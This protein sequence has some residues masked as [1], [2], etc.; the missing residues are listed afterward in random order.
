MLIG[1][2]WTFF[3]SGLQFLIAQLKMSGAM[4]GDMRLLVL[5]MIEPSAKTSAAGRQGRKYP[6]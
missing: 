3:A 1:P 5:L 6:K 4:S 2:Y